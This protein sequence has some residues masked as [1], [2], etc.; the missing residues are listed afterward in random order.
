MKVEFD[1][2]KGNIKYIPE[3]DWD[4]FRLGQAVERFSGGWD[5]C[6]FVNHKMTFVSFRAVGMIN[7]L[8]NTSLAKAKEEECQTP[9]K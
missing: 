1:K 7:C 8:L 9:S 3:S 6:E 5:G 4:I 2:K